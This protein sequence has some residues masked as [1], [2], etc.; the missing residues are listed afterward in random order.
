MARDS[1]AMKINEINITSARY[2]IMREGKGGEE[3]CLGWIF[4]YGETLHIQ[5]LTGAPS[6]RFQ[7]LS[8]LG[9]FFVSEVAK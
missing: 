2:L 1:R 3:R 8:L 7:R 5:I 6:L 9:G 4:Q